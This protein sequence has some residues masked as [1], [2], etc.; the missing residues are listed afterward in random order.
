MGKNVAETTGAHRPARWTPASSTWFLLMIGTWI[1]FGVAAVSYPDML[2]DYWHWGQKLPLAA[3]IGLW[4]GTLPWMLAIAV[5]ETSW[6][7]W[8]QITL[9]VGLAVSWVLFSVPRAT[10]DRRGAIRPE[11]RPREP[12]EAALPRH[13][14]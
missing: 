6:T 9:I 12:S 4:I 8:L 10:G 5:F 11:L 3:E 7:E 2:T 1:A 14:R 13:T